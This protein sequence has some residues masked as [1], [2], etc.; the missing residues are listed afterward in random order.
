MASGKINKT[1]VDR[2]APADRVQLFWDAELKGFG[3]KVTPKGRKV[4]VVDYRMPGKRGSNRYTIGP[5]GSPWTPDTARA[6][7]K[8]RLLEISQGVD[9][10]AEK[11]RRRSE[12]IDYA[13]SAYA[14]QFAER[15]LKS[16]WPGSYDRAVSTLRRHAIPYFGKR[17]IRDI[18]KADCAA[19][20]D[21]LWEMEATARK[22]REV[23]GKLFGWAEDRGD[24]ERS[25]MERVPAPK[26]GIGRERVLTDQELAKVWSACE[27]MKSHPYA[28]LVQ[29]LIFSG[30]RRGEVGG[31]LWDEIDWD[32]KLW[33]VPA[34]RTKSRRGNVVP[35][36]QPMVTLLGNLPRLGPLVFSITGENEL[37][38]HSKLKARLD[39][40][41]EESSGQILDHWTLHD[42]RRTVA[43]GLQRLGIG[44]DMIELIQGRT[45]KLG[46]GIRYQRYDYLDEKREATNR[47]TDHVI[48]VFSLRP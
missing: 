45:R 35:L 42:L 4:Y 11:R 3:V 14:K 34:G 7:A 46:A 13:F 1:A 47:W 16:N 36:T 26:P 30:Q 5:H 43:T 38:N 18:S 8:K 37:G 15:Y 25:P 2:L 41:V 21:S 10:N 22:A 19:F 31:M 12:T 39:G 48:S 29:F 6:E 20:I 9:P 40:L 24:I 32:R 44:S 23:V 33:E 27:A 17:D 28:P